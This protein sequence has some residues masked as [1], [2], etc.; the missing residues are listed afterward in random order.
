MCEI[1]RTSFSRLKANDCFIS[2]D[3]TMAENW[4]IKVADSPLDQLEADPLVT[5]VEGKADAEPQMAK[6]GTSQEP[7]KS[8][9]G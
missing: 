8:S 5:G 2:V 1:N 3:G 6:D 4:P 7:E 9:Q